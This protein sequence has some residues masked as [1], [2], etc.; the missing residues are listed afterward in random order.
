MCEQS[1]N[2]NA[3]SKRHNFAVISERFAWLFLHISLPQKYENY[4]R[5]GIS[6]L[7]DNKLLL[8]C[9]TDSER[10]HHCCHLA[11][12]VDNITARQTRLNF[13]MGREMTQKLN[14]GTS[15]TICHILCQWCGLIMQIR[16]LLNDEHI[17]KLYLL[18]NARLQTLPPAFPQVL[19][20][21]A[22]S[23]CQWKN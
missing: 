9:S 17:Y 16:L 8:C 19:Y 4:T 11:N 2:C 18:N 22:I 14:N 3:L 6:H 10:L 21:F 12:K 23:Y 20:A 1:T 15:V 5:N 7:I 13:T